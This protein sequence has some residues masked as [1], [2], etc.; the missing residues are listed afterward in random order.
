MLPIGRSQ[1]QRALRVARGRNEG[2]AVRIPA[3]VQRLQ[4]GRVVGKVVGYENEHQQL[5][6]QTP[7]IDVVKRQLIELS[8]T[9]RAESRSRNV[10]AGQ[11]LRRARRQLDLHFVG[12][13]HLLRFHEGIADQGDM[14]AGLRAGRRHRFAVEEPPAVGAR[15][16]P[17]IAVVGPANFSQGFPQ[18]AHRGHEAN[19]LP[20]FHEGDGQ[21]QRDLAAARDEGQPGRE[22]QRVAG[23]QTQQTRGI[24]CR[25]AWPMLRPA[26][27]NRARRHVDSRAG[28][29]DPDPPSAKSNGRW[30][31][32]RDRCP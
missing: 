23:C 10:P 5:R 20:G 14:A 19:R 7:R 2:Q 28:A 3:A 12:D 30:R 13:G 16:G 9:A 1:L 21:P 8:G 15:G 18:V 6:S 22:H 27:F 24:R 4:H 17:V 26:R 25:H 31:D 11:R 29:T 32:S